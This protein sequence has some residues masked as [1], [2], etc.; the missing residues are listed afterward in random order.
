MTWETHF[1]NLAE[2]IAKKSKD[3]HTKVGCVLVD[4]WD[5]TPVATG[6]N[7]FP[8]G[9][10]D[11]E[12]LWQRPTKY[13]YVIHAEEN[14]LLVAAR[15]GVRLYGATAYLTIPPCNRCLLRLE[16]AGIRSIVVPSECTEAAM[17]TD[18]DRAVRATILNPNN[19]R[20]ARFP[21]IHYYDRKE[22]NYTY[23]QSLSE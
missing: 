4:S 20:E 19:W 6:Y 14:A 10:H 18:H 23:V 16:Q 15:K 7:G 11:R 2:E 3:P 17:I 13:D 1:L 12:D 21:I 9:F 22:N 8:S 5:Q